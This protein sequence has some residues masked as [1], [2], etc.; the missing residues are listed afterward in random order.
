MRFLEDEYH[1][2][3]EIGTRLELDWYAIGM[4]KASI[5]CHA[6][7]R[8]TFTRDA[9]TIFYSSRYAALSLMF[10]SKCFHRPSKTKNNVFLIDSENLKDQYL[11]FPWSSFPESLR[12]CMQSS[13]RNPSLKYQKYQKK[14]TDFFRK[15]PDVSECI[16][17]EER[18]GAR[19]S[20][21][22]QGGARLSL[23]A[24]A[25]GCHSSGLAG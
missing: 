5:E 22:E 10:R 2:F 19:R 23:Y 18:G 17:M 1:I 14:Q 7:A 6:T 4:I 24:V 25:A 20:K 8:L 21:E 15:R 16:R 9:V 11:R 3:N 12:S 13:L